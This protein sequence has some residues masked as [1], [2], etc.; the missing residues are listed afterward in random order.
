LGGDLSFER[1]PDVVSVGLNGMAF[2]SFDGLYGPTLVGTFTFDTLVQGTINFSM[3]DNITPMGG[4]YSARSYLAQTVSYTG[5][6]VNILDNNSAPVAQN[7]SL[8]FAKGAVVSGVL[9]ATDVDNDALQYSLISNGQK[10]FVV[11]T[12]AATGAYSYTP[13]NSEDVGSDSFSFLV[14]DSTV[15]SNVATV[16]ITISDSSVA[17][18]DSGVTEEDTGIV[19]NVVNNDIAVYGGVPSI[20]SVTQ[21][22]NGTVVNNGNGTL[23]Y[24]P[25][26]DFNGNDSFTYSVSTGSYGTASVNFVINP[27]NDAPVVSV[28]ASPLVILGGESSQLQALASDPDVG[29]TLSYNWLATPTSGGIFSNPAISNPVFN[30]LNITGDQT[31][32]L[33]VDVSDGAATTSGSI[34]ITVK[35]DIDG[36]GM[37]DSFEVANGLDMNNAADASLD[38][39]GDGLINLLEY[40]HESDPNN[41]DTDGDTLLDGYE[42]NA[43]RSPIVNEGVLTV[44]INSILLN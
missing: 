33:S 23:T 3:A 29:A 42:V 10:G 11:I 15:D 7:D 26:A 32:S 16:S 6:D 43:G 25:A 28:T 18:D 41:P 4:F 37:A 22:A 40:Q 5:V 35:G 20:I 27:V 8:I 44:I 34:S 2:G 12:D 13:Y 38:G 14:N 17:F 39:D 24:T 30:S 9:V 21:P 31:Y 36:D 1:G 19:I